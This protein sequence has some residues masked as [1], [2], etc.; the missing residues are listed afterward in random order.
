MGIIIVIIVFS[1]DP[2]CYRSVITDRMMMVVIY[3]LFIYRLAASLGLFQ[4]QYRQQNRLVG[5][6]LVSEFDVQVASGKEQFHLL[7]APESSG[8]PTR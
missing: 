3:I 2:I 4:R 8:S 5:G 1:A 7:I 6:A